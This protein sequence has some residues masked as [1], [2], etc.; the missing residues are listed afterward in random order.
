[1]DPEP[2]Q[3]ESGR[4][5]ACDAIGGMCSG[6]GRMY[7]LWERTPGYIMRDKSRSLSTLIPSHDNYLFYVHSEVLQPSFHREMPSPSSSTS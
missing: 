2:G 5:T 1:M 3:V 4:E 6:R 7:N